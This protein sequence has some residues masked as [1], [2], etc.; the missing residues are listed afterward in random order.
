MKSG[1]KN[2]DSTFLMALGR[3]IQPWICPLSLGNIQS[4]FALCCI[5]SWIVEF[6]IIIMYFIINLKDR[7]SRFLRTAWSVLLLFNFVKSFFPPFIKDFTLSLVKP[8]IILTKAHCYFATLNLKKNWVS[9]ILPS[10]IAKN[11]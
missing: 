9:L 8:I 4:F 1:S 10:R 5:F 11:S 2:M 7:V 3:L 6:D